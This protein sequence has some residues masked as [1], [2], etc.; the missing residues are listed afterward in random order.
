MMP[1]MKRQRDF[2][3]KEYKDPEHLALS[4]AV[5][6]DLEKFTRFLERAEG[7]LHLNPIALAVD[8][9]CGNGRNL[10]YLAERY[11]MRGIGY[12]ISDEA[13]K[14]AQQLSEGLPIH[15][16]ARSIDGDFSGIKDGSVSLVLDMMSSHF[17]KRAAREHLRDEI[18]RILRPGGWLF[19]K[20]FLGEGDL[21]AQRMLKD[22]PAGEGE[23]NAY[24]HPR[25]G[26]YE[27]VW[28]DADA[29][30]EFFEPYFEVHKVDK[31]HRH[32]TKHGEPNKRRTVAVYLQKQ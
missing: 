26:V 17:L 20:S 30:R 9:G 19:F 25:L 1:R 24:I 13:I 14:Q 3:N 4:T 5:S 6:E 23:D 31:S 2:W 29:I 8:L 12:D 15:Y 21:N 18:V 27:Y 32:L 7:K 28:R 16:E 11:G 10:I 22:Y